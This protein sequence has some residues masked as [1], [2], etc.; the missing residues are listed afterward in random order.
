MSKRS[1]V[2]EEQRS[3]KKE[4]VQDGFEEEAVIKETRDGEFIIT[5]KQPYARNH[6]FVDEELDEEADD[7]RVGQT[8]QTAVEPEEESKTHCV[9]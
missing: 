9:V 3:G 6:F 4:Q 8:Y 2:L 5:A 7:C 1:H